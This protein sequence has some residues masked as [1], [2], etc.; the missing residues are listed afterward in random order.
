MTLTYVAVT[1]RTVTLCSS[2]SYMRENKATG[3]TAFLLLSECLLAP[4]LT[5]Y[6]TTGCW[7]SLAVTMRE[8]TDTPIFQASTFQ[9]CFIQPVSLELLMWVSREGEW[10]TFH[11][12]QQLWCVSYR[13]LF[14]IWTKGSLAKKVWH[15]L[16]SISVPPSM[17]QE[18]S[19]CLIKRQYV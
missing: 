11:S 4:Y 2:C 6:I 3:M 10:E 15:L 12:P 16:L 19:V 1:R 8:N 14:S 9:L 7:V 18:I 13:F 17:A 5:N